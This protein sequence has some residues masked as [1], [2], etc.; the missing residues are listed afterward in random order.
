MHGFYYGDE[1]EKIL[2][3]GGE[4]RFTY[5]ITYATIRL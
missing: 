1:G 3:K 4:N 2:H 5:V